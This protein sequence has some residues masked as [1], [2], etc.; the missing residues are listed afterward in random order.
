MSG[1]NFKTVSVRIKP[2][3]KTTAV[4]GLIVALAVLTLPLASL[5]LA[6][7]LGLAQVA[8]CSNLSPS[9]ACLGLPQFIQTL[10]AAFDWAGS[11]MGRVLWAATVDT[12]LLSTG[13]VGVAL[14]LGVGLAWLTSQYAFRGRAVFEV[15]L[16]T[17]LA[18]PG[19]VAAY[20]WVSLLAYDSP[21]SNALRTLGVERLPDIRN[22]AGAALVLS[23]AL[24]PYVYAI[25]R[26][27]F[28]QQAARLSEVAA[29]LGVSG[30]A[31]FWRIHGPLAR[32]AVAA[33]ASLVLMETLADYG[34]SAYLG[35]NTL[36]V[37]VYKT[38]FAAEQKLLAIA[39]VLCLLSLCAVLVWLEKRSRG[40]A[41]R[42][43]MRSIAQPR[44]P[45][46]TSLNPCASAAATGVCAAIFALGFAIPVFTLLAMWLGDVAASDAAFWQSTAW[47]RMW[48]ALWHS[49]SFA[50][51]G[52]S[53][54]VCL[55]AASL[56][57][58]RWRAGTL[59]ARLLSHLGAMNQLGYA[60]PGV[61]IAL[62]ILW[63]VVAFDRI[64]AQ[65]FNTGLLIT[66]TGAAVVLAYVIRFYAVA[67]QSIQGG[68]ARHSPRLQ[69]AAQSLGAG[70]GRT[71]WRIDAPLLAP[72]YA[73]AWVL[74]WIDCLKE[75]PA[76]LMLRPFNSDTLPVLVFQ[77]IA[78]ERAAQAALPSLILTAVGLV[79]VLLC[80]RWRSKQ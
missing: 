30:T 48:P 67:Q 49:V 68:I 6:G 64:I 17:P 31:A 36:T 75:L 16:L 76:T 79:P 8:A 62:A 4:A 25:A 39:T 14:V 70:A 73:T 55:V 71:F 56:W 10:S 33:G 52:A 15:L 50:A 23:L 12:A 66:G 27:A 57:L 28:T 26:V 1:L 34:V 60:V 63:P 59:S 19:Y 65:Q 7:V 77:W 61:A 38:W 24:F 44:T 22:T 54:L 35:V 5:L 13:V 69:D 58:Q 11:G 20:A 72:T 41:Q 40:A 37:T 51:I 3:L 42:F 2:I 47:Q 45:L 21:L 18:L 43:E 9:S 32:P 80:L 78:D 53:V 29:S 74:V 46:R